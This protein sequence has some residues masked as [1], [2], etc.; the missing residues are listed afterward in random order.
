MR[1]VFKA[2]R[3]GWN[4]DQDGIWFDSDDLTREEAEAEFKPYQGTTQQGYPYTGY[5]YD[6][7]KYHDFTYLG[8]YEDDKMPKN[9]TEF[10]ASLRERNSSAQ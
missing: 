9:D 5:E 10:F 4:K 6:G 8:E 7:V 3:L 2:T 1:H